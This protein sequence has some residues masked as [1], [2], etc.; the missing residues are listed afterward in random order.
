[1]SEYN[2]NNN[3]TNDPDS[4]NEQTKNNDNLTDKVY[5]AAPQQQESHANMQGANEQEPNE[6]SPAQHPYVQGQFSEY[7][8]QNTSTSYSSP[9]SP[10]H[11]NTQSHPYS[12]PYYRQ[13]NNTTGASYTFSNDPSF[14][15]NINNVSEKKKK[16]KSSGVFKSIAIV[17]CCVILAGGFGFGGAFLYGYMFGNPGTPSQNNTNNSQDTEQSTPDTFPDEN[18]APVNI[19]KVE[20]S[21]TANTTMTDVI[22][23]VRDTVVEIVTENI[24][25]SQFYGQYVTSGAGSGVIING[26]GYIV[27]NNH[28]VDGANTIYVRTTD[29]KEYKAVLVGADEE[30]DVAVIKIDATG[31]KAATLGDSSA[32]KLG[33]DVIAIGNPLGSLGGTVTNGIISALDREVTIDGQKMVLLQTNAAVN[34]GNSGGGLFNMAGELIGVVNAKSSSSSSG[35]TIEGLGF[36]IPINHAFDVSSQLIEYGYVKGKVSLGISVYSYERDMVYK[37]GFT[38]YTIKAGVY[39]E[40][41]GKNTEL[42]KDDRFISIDGTEVSATTDIKEIL[43]AHKVGDTIKATVARTQDNKEVH[44]EVTLKCFEYVPA[45]NN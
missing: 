22:S 44:I 26:N 20:G 24:Q 11:S 6:Q 19:N 7:S 8:Q 21:T 10:Q 34:P 39:V 13:V 27:T 38:Y 9:Y 31:L 33:E 28:V 30:S 32:I 12:E 5:D 41:P 25:E 43:A 45:S 36:A 17:L 37:Q 40:D 15:A 18:R 23:A 29:E 35:T 42:Q 1:M 14:G 3:H 2:I 4:E 16:K